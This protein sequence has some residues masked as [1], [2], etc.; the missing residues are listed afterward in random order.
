MFRKI[1]EFISDTNQIRKDLRDM[2]AINIKKEKGFIKLNNKIPL[3]NIEDDRK[4]ILTKNNSLVQVVKFEGLDFASMNKE[5]REE[6]YIKR[7][8]FFDNLDPKYFVTFYYI[9][10]KETNVLNSSLEFK[11]KYSEKIAN[12]WQKNFEDSY[13]T[14]F[15]L[16]IK[17]RVKGNLVGV[18]DLALGRNANAEEKLKK[19]CYKFSREV[20]NMISFLD[21][22][23]PKVLW[24]GRNSSDLYSFWEYLINLRCSGFSG[25]KH[26]DVLLQL[27]TIEFENGLEDHGT[28]TFQGDDLD[29]DIT[30]NH[31]YGRVYNTKRFPDKK[32]NKEHANIIALKDYPLM[33]TEGDFNDLFKVK[34]NFI[35]WS[36]ITPVNREK[37]KS[38]IKYKLNL[39]KNIDL[40]GFFSSRVENLEEAGEHLEEGS[41]NFF[42]H[43]QRILVWG[44]SKEE[45]YNAYMDVKKSLADSNIP[46]ILEYWPENPYWSMFPDYESVSD[47]YRKIST[48]N[49]ANWVNLGSYQEGLQATSFGNEPITYFKTKTFSNFAFNFH[50]TPRSMATGHTFII[51]GTGEGKSTLISF[52]LMN[53]L[54]YKNFKALVFDSK[55]GLKIPTKSFGGIYADSD[56]I[57]F[58]PLQLKDTP[59]NREFLL[60]FVGM[61]A[62][63]ELEP[64][65]TNLVQEAINQSYSILANGGEVDLSAI[66]DIVGNT[67]SEKGKLRDR[68]DPWLPKKDKTIR[69]SIFNAEKDIL[70]FSSQVTTFDFDEILKS[71]NDG[72]YSR[73]LVFPL[74]EYIFHVFQQEIESNPAPHIV[75][76]DEMWKYLGSESFAAKI[77]EFAKELRK[78]NGV[79]IGAIQDPQELTDAK[80]GNSLIQNCA[81]IIFF[82]NYKANKD[83]FISTVKADRVSLGLNETEFA[84]IKEMSKPNSRE[85]M[86]KKSS[87]NSIILDVNLKSIGE[88]LE[89][90]SSDSH[91]VHLFEELQ[92][93]TDNDDLIDIYLKEVKSLSME[94]INKTDVIISE[95]ENKES[96]SDRNNSKADFTTDQSKL[97][98]TIKKNIVDG[99]CGLTNK[100]L[101]EKAGIGVRKVTTTISEL[102]SLGV[103]NV[104]GSGKARKIE[105]N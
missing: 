104:T 95:E 103:V 10:K 16:V 1:K 98:A 30:P 66:A 34:R 48:A 8:G 56:K 81:N 68:L 24:H 65:E 57:N 17:R 3:L 42:W 47:R 9:R 52:L 86:L 25:L 84:W 78:R 4:T 75:F 67:E 45:A 83:H 5:Q 15:Y 23:S 88:D 55:K 70:D 97:L 36:N 7:K 85:I 99:L 54:K 58:N 27:K 40:I 74:T 51:G 50:D 63:R 39:L 73:D 49:L 21:D 19:E 71:E 92:E 82:K 20:E 101:S 29:L 14:S 18:T 62:Q 79:L 87:G 90:L 105:I 89:L 6:L 33:S 44:D 13:K 77:S 38:W 26:L 102:K 35:L 93:N 96:V 2:E 69:N 37:N 46:T 72:D 43:D 22:Y 64:R 12:K 28:I 76:I 61:L 80:K 32:H 59:K 11:N 94:E 31:K 53:C 41:I 91:K 60:K 100:E